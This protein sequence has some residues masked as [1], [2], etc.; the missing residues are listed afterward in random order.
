M[1]GA[2]PPACFLPSDACMSLCDLPPR[3]TPPWSDLY[4]KDCHVEETG[5]LM[6]GAANHAARLRAKEVYSAAE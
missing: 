5:L 3:A 4:R 6:S 1:S 2:H